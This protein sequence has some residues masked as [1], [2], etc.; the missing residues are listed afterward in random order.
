MMNTTRDNLGTTQDCAVITSGSIGEGIMMQGSDLDIMGV[1][2]KYEVREDANI[3]QN[4]DI[5]YLTLGTE[6]TK[7]GFITLRLVHSDHQKAPEFCEVIGE[8]YYFSNSKFK[9]YFLN[10]Y[11]STVH[12]P[13]ISDKK[14]RFF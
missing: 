10:S 4:H 6:D 2:K 9:H 1:M 11:L 8:K 7:P 13:C 12:G 14:N 5:M 3:R